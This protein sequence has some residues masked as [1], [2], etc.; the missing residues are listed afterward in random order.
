MGERSKEEKILY[1]RRLVKLDEGRL[2]KQIKNGWEDRMV[3]R[4]F[5]VEDEV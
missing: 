1:G 2:G 5:S 4:I 3:G